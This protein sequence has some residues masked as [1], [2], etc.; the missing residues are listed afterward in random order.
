MHLLTK[1]FMNISRINIDDS[2]KL[3]GLI[4]NEGEEFNFESYYSIL[5]DDTVEKYLK[6]T[7]RQMRR[8]M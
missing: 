7:E 1:C 2:D 5:R 6:E 3:I 8:S 4:S